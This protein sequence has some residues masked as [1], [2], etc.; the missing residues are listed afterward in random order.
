MSGL[1]GFAA[2]FL[3]GH[4]V[5]RVRGERTAARLAEKRRETAA[6][7][8]LALMRVSCFDHAIAAM[9]VVMVLKP[10]WDDGLLL[11]AMA[12]AIAIATRAFLLP[13]HAARAKR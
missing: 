13:P 6:A 8:A 10:W 7:E 9:A 1:A 5:L 2:T 11:A 4:F 12:A 3:T